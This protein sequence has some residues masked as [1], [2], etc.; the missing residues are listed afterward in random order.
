MLKTGR[1]Y[2]A[3]GQQAQTSSN[4]PP[5]KKSCLPAFLREKPQEQPVMVVATIK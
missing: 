2:Q 1:L 3:N 4:L 5:A